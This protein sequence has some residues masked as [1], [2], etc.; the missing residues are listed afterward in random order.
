MDSGRIFSIEFGKPVPFNIFLLSNSILWIVK[1]F[2][3]G[4]T[5]IVKE[6]QEE[7]TEG[8]GECRNTRKEG[9]LCGSICTI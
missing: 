2:Q 3:E 5:E 9:N 6:R 4:T 8:K 7:G 1:F